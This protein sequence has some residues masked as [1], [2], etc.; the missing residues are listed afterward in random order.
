M[1]TQV[2]GS[3]PSFAISRDTVFIDAL[4]GSTGTF[5]VLANAA[6]WTL[7]ENT[8]WMVVN[9]IS[10]NNTQSITIL[11][12]G[13]NIFGNQ[14]TATITASADGFSDTTITVIQR[15]STP[16]FEVAPGMLVLG[17]DSLDQV[18]FNITT[19]LISWT[20]NENA[21][22]MEVSPESGA[23]TQQIEVTASE[24]NRTNNTRSDIITISA[25]PLVP[26]TIMVT[27]DTIRAIGIKEENLSQ[28]IQVFPNP[29][30]GL[31]N[32]EIDPNYGG[33][34][35]RIQVFN[36]I[37]ASVIVETLSQT[38]TRQQLDLGHLPAGFYYLSIAVD[39]QRISKKISLINQ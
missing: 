2:D 37:G 6:N 19:N 39:N 14:R 29:T 34:N 32:I 4:Q 28:A 12:A 10:G 23:F 35:M 1:V 22:W 26:Q 8:P 7:S 30:N 9:P 33:K 36:T 11:A 13:R 5:S 18:S 3:T 25:P 21:N 31:L 16:L 17:S 24:T 15:P 20:I 27:Q 38:T